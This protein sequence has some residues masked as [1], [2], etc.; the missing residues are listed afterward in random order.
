MKLS[1]SVPNNHNPSL[2]ITAAIRYESEPYFLHYVLDDF[3]VSV[4]VIF[5]I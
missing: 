3:C 4:K 1:K 2:I 5:P